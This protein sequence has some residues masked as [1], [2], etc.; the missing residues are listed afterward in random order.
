MAAGALPKT[1]RCTWHPSGVGVAV[2]AECARTPSPRARYVVPTLQNLPG[3]TLSP[4]R[5]D[6]IAEIARRHD[7]LIIKDDIHV[8]LTED[9]PLP[10]AAR[11]PERTLYLQGLSKI[12]KVGLRMGFLAAPTSLLEKLRAGVR[13]SIWNPAP[14]MA[15]I[16]CRWIQ[17]GTG[18]RVA[19]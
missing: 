2:R 15:E 14:L 17:E 1:V 3:V 13:S 11:A 4:N 19:E 7:L 6:T 12:P 10:I 9:P 8:F 5:R 18:D 16:T